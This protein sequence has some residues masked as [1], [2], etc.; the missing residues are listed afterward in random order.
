MQISKAPTFKT[1]KIVSKGIP[2]RVLH[3]LRNS[4]Y[5]QGIEMDFLYKYARAPS[6]VKLSYKTL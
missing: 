3:A 6:Q 2:R 4:S 1:I 5:P